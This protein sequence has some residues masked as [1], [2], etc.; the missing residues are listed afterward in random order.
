MMLFWFGVRIFGLDWYRITVKSVLRKKLTVDRSKNWY[1][2]RLDIKAQIYVFGVENLSKITVDKWCFPPTSKNRRNFEFWT[3][4][5][6]FIGFS[7]LQA[8][9]NVDSTVRYPL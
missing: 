9:V 5:V 7:V 2:A 6:V 1:L 8:I 3:K 4:F